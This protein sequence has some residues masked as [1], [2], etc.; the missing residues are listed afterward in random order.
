[1]KTVYIKPEVSQVD[2]CLDYS[3]MMSCGAS[4]EAGPSLYIDDEDLYSF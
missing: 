2:L 1:M 4:G 3:L